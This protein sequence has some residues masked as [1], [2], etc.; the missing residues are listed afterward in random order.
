MG[1]ERTALPIS[2][3]RIGPECLNLT[4]PSDKLEARVDYTYSNFTRELDQER[5]YDYAITRGRLT[6]QA[7]KYLFFRGI[8]EYNSFRKDL[9]T[10]F[11]A[12]FLYIPGTVIHFGYGSLYESIAWRG[13]TLRSRRP[14][15][16]VPSGA[17][18]QSV[19]LVADVIQSALPCDWIRVK[20]ENLLHDRVVSRPV[21]KLSPFEIAHKSAA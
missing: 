19:L 16:E 17:F 15:P 3:G 4:V 18:L 6:Y 5:I 21:P 1:L 12:S 13:G 2:W 14:V 10:D 8:L 20:P 7:N 11:L 9:L